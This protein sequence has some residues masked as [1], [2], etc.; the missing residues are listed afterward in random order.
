MLVFVGVHA[1]L[2]IVNCSEFETASQKTKVKYVAASAL[3]RVK[4]A[5]ICSF[6]DL[7]S[8]VQINLGR[9][10]RKFS[11]FKFYKVGIKTSY[12]VITSLTAALSPVTHSFSHL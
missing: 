12:R 8:A 7:E 10:F 3:S 9:N 5:H 6:T 4:S 11:V 2:V 1:H